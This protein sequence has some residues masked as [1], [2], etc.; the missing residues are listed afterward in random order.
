M[1]TKE[2]TQFR[3]QVLVRFQSRHRGMR[4]EDACVP[5]KAEAAYI[6]TRFVGRGVL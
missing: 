6:L 4:A 1:K 5:R 3:Y 2:K